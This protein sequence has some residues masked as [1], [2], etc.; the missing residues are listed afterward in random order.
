L[1]TGAS[2]SVKPVVRSRNRSIDS[3]QQIE[4]TKPILKHHGRSKSVSSTQLQ[5]EKQTLLLTE[6]H[7]DKSKIRISSAKSTPFGNGARK[8][9]SKSPYFQMGVSKPLVM[10]NLNNQYAASKE[11]PKVNLSSSVSGN[12]QKRAKPSL[13]VY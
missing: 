5:R 8:G 2:E 7:S 13:Q 3:F 12:D 1:Q 6:N 4:K 11:S 10:K 9:H